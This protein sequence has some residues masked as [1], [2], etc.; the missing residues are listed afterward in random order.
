MC[1]LFCM[2]LGEISFE[3]YSAHLEQ[4]AEIKDETDGMPVIEIAEE[5]VSTVETPTV[6]KSSTVGRPGK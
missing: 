2:Y 5:T 4:Q 3:E 6:G 1:T